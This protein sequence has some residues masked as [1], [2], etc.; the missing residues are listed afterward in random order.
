[1]PAQELVEGRGVTARGPRCEGV[2]I[3]R[4]APHDADQP[5]CCM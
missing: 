5:G 2:V 3:I 4:L 1:V